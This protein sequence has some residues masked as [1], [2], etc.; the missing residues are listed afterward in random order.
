MERNSNVLSASCHLKKAASGDSKTS[1][2]VSMRNSVSYLPNS[3]TQYQLSNRDI[4]RGEEFI[5]LII[6]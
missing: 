3:S 1:S 5:V 2:V 6:I 4:P